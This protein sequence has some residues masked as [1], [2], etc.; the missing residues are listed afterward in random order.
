M[1]GYIFTPLERQ[2]IKRL[3]AGERDKPILNIL[4]RIKL[5][6]DLASDVQLYLKIRE[7]M[8]TA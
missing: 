5:S 1:R 2:R 3:L 4:S 6:T 8:E 7:A